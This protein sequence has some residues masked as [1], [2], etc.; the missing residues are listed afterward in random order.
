MYPVNL[1][2]PTGILES[3]C[4]GY[5]AGIKKNFDPLE[6]LLWGTVSASFTGEGTGPFYGV[7]SVPGLIQSRFNFA[8]ELV[9][10]L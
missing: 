5:L 10:N 1:I 4:G 6:A 9:K 2:D 7:D 3:F 8:S